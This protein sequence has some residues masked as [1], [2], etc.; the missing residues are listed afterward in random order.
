METLEQ[1]KR[2]NEINQELDALEQQRFDII[3]KIS[4]LSE[5]RATIYASLL[6]Y[7]KTNGVVEEECN[8]AFLNYF[9]KED[10]AWL[11]DDGLLAKLK[12]DGL[13]DYIKVTTK[14]SIDKTKLKKDFKTNDSLK[15]SYQA[16]YGT[17]L[18]EYVTVT[19]PE[20]HTRMLEHIEENKK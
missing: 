12:E 19:T 2:A 3:E 14:E 9:S 8:G 5:E 15:E 6:D 1:V 13:K 7:C 20:N 18:T 11:D 16:F 4:K 17:K 10:V